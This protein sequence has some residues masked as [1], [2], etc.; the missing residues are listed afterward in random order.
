MSLFLYGSLWMDTIA[1][2]INEIS[3]CAGMLYYNTDNFYTDI[4]IT[5]FILLIEIK[6]VEIEYGD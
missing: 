5:L 3:G 2:E 6:Y 1:G 4:Y